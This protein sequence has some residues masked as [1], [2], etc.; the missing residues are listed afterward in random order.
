MPTNQTHQKN[1][2][3][4]PKHPIPPM[5]AP[6]LTFSLIAII[7]LFALMAI[8]L[9]HATPPPAAPVT[10]APSSFSAAR[11]MLRLQHIATKSHPIGT[12]ANVE[13]R[14]YLMRE[15]SA[16]GLS[17]EV[18]SA[19]GIHGAKFGRGAGIVQNIIV[20]LPGRV[21]GKALMLA[22]H[23]DSVPLS[24]GAG[25][26]GASVAAIVE[27]I[28]ALK[29]GPP[30]Q[31]DLICVLTD[32]EE[33]GLLGA[34][35]F[36]T[37]HPWANSIGI[38]FNFEYRGNSGPML[39]FETT[40][41]NG[42]LIDGLKTVPLP[43]G[44]SLMYEIYKRLPNDTDMTVFERGG[45]AGLNFA[46]VE[47]A[48]SYHTE[49]DRLDRL[50][51]GSLQ[52]QGDIMLALARYFGNA[53]LNHLQ[54]TDS[55]Y[56]DVAG[57]GMLSYPVSWRWPLAALVIG[58][59]GVALRLGKKA[60]QVR[61]A[62]VIGGAFGFLLVTALLGA[63]SALSWLGLM[64]LYPGYGQ[65]LTGE[66]YNS[67]WYLLAFVGLVTGLFILIQGRLTTWLQPMEFAL[68]AA[69]CWVL[70][71]A[72]ATVALPGATF[73]FV[74]PLIPVL[75][76]FIAWFS[77]WGQKTSNDLKLALLLAGLAPG[78]L[79]FAPLIRQIYVGL[80]VQMVGVAMVILLL[81]LGIMTPLLDAL[82][83][84]GRRAFPL[85]LLAGGGIF[86]ILAALNA[87][88][89]AAHPRP[90]NLSY[91][92]VGNP[93]TAFWLSSD[94]VL[95]SWTQGYFPG[96]TTR[97]AMPEVFGKRFRL[98]WAADTPSLH[99]P[100]PVIDVVEDQVMPE[101][102][103][104]ILNIR[105]QR[106]APM[107]IMAIED[108]DVLR[109]RFQGRTFSDQPESSWLL[110][111]YGVPEAGVVVNLTVPAGVPFRVR[112]MDRTYGLPV[113]GKPLRPADVI[114]QPFSDSETAQV[115]SVRDFK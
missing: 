53:D 48:S 110:A 20:K 97:R 4:L 66:T 57:A 96:V 80:T 25:D 28:R 27:T 94:P 26:D 55:V 91:A 79:M 77:G 7:A 109:S 114:G 12:T 8:G 45:M 100:E 69:A 111:A 75:L 11:A 23:Y 54:A 14:D 33:A 115:V 101:G 76:I 98:L 49:L 51:Q 9:W 41:G 30:L 19:V 95:D 21:P 59:W 35:A 18:R 84:A 16:M 56:F 44:N 2:N 10:A 88:F 113:A 65:L 68:G 38:A 87:D 31:N 3:A 5:A 81:L 15:F 93:G 24:F 50:N 86:L 62:R 13:V 61:P 82:A 63:A 40:A 60:A 32:G 29:S 89:D 22:A 70:M 102:R 39:M 34:D 108:T 103:N 42:K 36:V 73:L 106:H 90:D 105:S 1:Q 92:Q 43:L 83:R 112:I 67:H 85:A 58:L 64:K 74:W 107:F 46:A 52:H 6:G 37:Q 72:G 47:S 71:L 104:L 78:I 17:P 99:F